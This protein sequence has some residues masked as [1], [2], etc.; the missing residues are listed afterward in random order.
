MKKTL[1]TVV[2]LAMAAPIFSFEWGG[3][4]NNGGPAVRLKW[5][6]DMTSEIGVSI[7]YKNAPGANH[8][9]ESIINIY[10]APLNMSIIRNE[11][12]TV[13]LGIR[14]K[15]TIEYIDRQDNPFTVTKSFTA[16]QYGLTLLVPEIE[17]KIP[18]IS[19]LALVGAAGVDFSWDFSAATSKPTQFTTSLFCSSLSTLGVIY[20]FGAGEIPQV[21]QPETAPAQQPAV[22]TEPK[23]AAAPLQ[24]PKPAPEKQPAA[25]KAES[26]AN[27]TNAQNK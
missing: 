5:Q 23:A 21:K 17:V 15:D 13:N 12:A 7:S 10:I 8:D 18:W 22:K 1:L 11:F 4:Y 16:N 3:G 27:T 25:V 2:I 6:D 19:G 14:L 20:Y 26:Q 24:Q 9:V